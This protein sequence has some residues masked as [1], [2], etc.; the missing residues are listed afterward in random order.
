MN[1]TALFYAL[2]QSPEFLVRWMLLQRYLLHDSENPLAISQVYGQLVILTSFL[3]LQ[4][5][6]PAAL[7]LALGCV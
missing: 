3:S 2:I 6:D 7:S 1:R 5:R 4:S